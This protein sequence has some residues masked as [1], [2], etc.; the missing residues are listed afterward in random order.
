MCVSMTME[1]RG[2]KD[3]FFWIDPQ[4]LYICANPREQLELYSPTWEAKCFMGRSCFQ[5]YLH[6]QAYEWCTNCTVMIPFVSNVN[7]CSIA[8]SSHSTVQTQGRS[9]PQRGAD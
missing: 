1:E 8:L 6:H 4:L 7:I 2:G 9:E 5:E 3:V